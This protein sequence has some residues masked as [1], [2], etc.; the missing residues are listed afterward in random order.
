MWV[1]FAPGIYDVRVFLSQW[2]SPGRHTHQP[3]VT[4][5]CNGHV[6]FGFHVQEEENIGRSV[7]I[8]FSCTS[9]NIIYC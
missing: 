9:L 3:S 2:F 5:T 8:S 4:A 1:C 6:R 7:R